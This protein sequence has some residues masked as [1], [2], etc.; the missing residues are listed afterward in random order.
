MNLAELSA[1]LLGDA[2]RIV[3]ATRDPWPPPY[4]NRALS[5]LCGALND[6]SLHFLKGGLCAEA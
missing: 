3:Y 2:T 5:Q 6:E 1:V 4:K